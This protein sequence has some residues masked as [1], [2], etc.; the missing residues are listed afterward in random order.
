M[1]PF[2]RHLIYR[3]N[4]PRHIRV[5]CSKEQPKNLFTHKTTQA[6][7]E[8]QVMCEIA[9]VSDNLSPF[10]LKKSSHHE[11]EQRNEH[12]QDVMDQW[13]KRS[14]DLSP[15]RLKRSIYPAKNDVEED[16]DAFEVSLGE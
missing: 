15:F 12:Q 4:D 6:T 14:G 1:V 13:F 5:P 9:L 16:W 3:K 10:R 8:P 11:E 7:R 2:S